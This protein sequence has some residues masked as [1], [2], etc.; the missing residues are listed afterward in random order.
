MAKWGLAQRTLGATDATIEQAF[1]D[2]TILRTHVLRPTW[3]FVLPADIRWMLELT[4]PRV[5]VANSF[6]Q[7][8]LELDDALYRR[9]NAALVKALKGGK[10]LTRDEVRS[11]WKRAGMGATDGL[12]FAYLMMR[13]EL[14]G[15]VCSGARRGKQFTYALLDERAPQVKKLERDKAL[16]EL[17][18][19]YFTSRG[20]ATLRDFVWWSGLTMTDAKRGME[21]A[22]SNFVREV[23]EEQTYWFTESAPAAQT[24]SITAHLLPIYDEY[25]ASYRDR[26]AAMDPGR[27]KKSEA[28]PEVPFSHALTINGKVV[29]H[30][31]RTIKKNSV[32]VHLYPFTSLTK[33]E[34]SAVQDAVQQYGAFL[35]MPARLA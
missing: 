17:I 26:T 31:K 33:M 8:K 14:D 34:Q 29:G 5:R 27:S 18:L 7:R 15:L 6:L 25:P 19:R 28:N 11:V 23:I 2:G 12:R 22:K 9:S 10:Q 21:I 20:P 13:A 30:W 32:L 4:G 35:E 16:S 3:H 24:K 1:T